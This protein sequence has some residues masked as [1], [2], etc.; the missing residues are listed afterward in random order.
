VPGAVILTSEAE[1]LSADHDDDSDRDDS[2]I[3][4]ILVLP[5]NVVILPINK[6]NISNIVGTMRN[7]PKPPPS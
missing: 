7:I 1:I 4:I 6:H 5:Q 2:D 3:V